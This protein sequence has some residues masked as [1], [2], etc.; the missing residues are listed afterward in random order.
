MCKIAEY[1][2]RVIYEYLNKRKAT[3]KIYNVRVSYW[4]SGQMV[5]LQI[6]KLRFSLLTD[7]PQMEM[8]DAVMLAYWPPFTKLWALGWSPWNECPR[9]LQHSWRILAVLYCFKRNSVSACVTPGVTPGVTPSGICG[10]NS[11]GY[12]W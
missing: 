7:I 5:H 8:S 10:R 12:S 4:L 11:T 9:F 1:D 6:A 3:P 2:I